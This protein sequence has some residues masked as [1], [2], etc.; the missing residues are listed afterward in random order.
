MRRLALAL[1]CSAAL[2]SAAF[3]QQ[4]PGPP[5]GASAPPPPH[6]L[7]REHAE[8]LGIEAATVEQIRQIAES[9][10]AERE[11]AEKA[12]KQAR[13]TLMEL[14]QVDEPDR[15]AVLAQVEVLGAAETAQLRHSLE[16]LLDIHALLTPAQLKALEAM[17]PPGAPPGGGPPP[18]GPPGGG[19]PPRPGAR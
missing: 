16:V 13:A 18:G 7:I 11:A 12:V 3:A 15:A 2:C 14:L 1:I 17:R 5:S 6:E 4:P 19:P 9:A 8:A 10:R